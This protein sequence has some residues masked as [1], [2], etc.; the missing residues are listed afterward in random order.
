MNTRFKTFIKV[1]DS[2]SFNKAAENLYI[3]A[4]AV[5]KQINSLE[6]EIDIELFKRTNQ[7]LTLTEAGKMIQLWKCLLLN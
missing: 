5:I 1:A 2:G 7:G 4:P 6:K 3:S